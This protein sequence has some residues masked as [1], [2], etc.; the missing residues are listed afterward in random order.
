MVVSI[1]ISI[2]IYYFVIFYYSMVSLLINIMVVDQSFCVLVLL[3]DTN[4]LFSSK[5]HCFYILFLSTQINNL[6]FFD[7][8]LS[9]EMS[10]PNHLISNI[11]RYFISYRIPKYNFISMNCYI[12]PSINNNCTHK[13]I[14]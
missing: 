7:P 2:D 11:Q 14:S 5:S 13:R 10:L 12:D 3:E 6:G 1:Y 4:T 9:G 8:L